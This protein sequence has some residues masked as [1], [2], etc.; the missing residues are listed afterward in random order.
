MQA[1][2]RAMREDPAEVKARRLALLERRHA[3]LGEEFNSAAHARSTGRAH[4][5]CIGD[6]HVREIAAGLAPEH[7]APPM[8]HAWVDTC[9]VIGATAR[10]L[11]NPRSQTNA[12]YMFQRRIELA[13]TWQQL[14]FQLGEVD[15]GYMIWQRAEKRGDSVEDLM[16]TSI[17]NYVVFLDGVRARG[18]EALFVL[19]A[20]ATGDARASHR[21]GE[22]VSQQERTDLTVRFNQELE[23][24]AGV[25]AFV[26]ITTPTLDPATGL[27]A[28][29]FLK[30]PVDH[31][32]APEPY[33]RLIADRLG[34][35]LTPPS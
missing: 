34:P 16:Q 31:H 9:S 23:R 11:T 10:G 18:F 33:V 1:D 2:N 35:H 5:I 29:A 24:R 15:C 13:R 14:V 4:V 6:S 22:T 3:A 19:S 8:A 30:D 12:L 28:P 25:F 26:D 20:P 17:E 7:A 27:V 21:E 32:L